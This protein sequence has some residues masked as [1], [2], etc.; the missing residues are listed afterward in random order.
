MCIFCVLSKALVVVWVFCV[1]VD[2]FL[3]FNAPIDHIY[4]K[5][6][7]LLLAHYYRHVSMY[8]R[9]IGEAN[10]EYRNH[11]QIRIHPSLLPFLRVFVIRIRFDIQFV[12]DESRIGALWTQKPE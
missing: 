2:F 10:G 8:I 3:I 12:A 7:Q 4:I 5:D 11:R 9:S 6:V 1:R